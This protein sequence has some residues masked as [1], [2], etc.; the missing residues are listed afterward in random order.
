MNNFPLVTAPLLRQKRRVEV[1]NM[2]RLFRRLWLV[3]A[4]CAGVMSVAQ[5]ETV[6]A[7]KQV[8]VGMYI[9]DITAV[10]LSTNSYSVDFYLWFRWTDP[11]MD[12]V[13]GF[14]FMNMFNPDDHV[15]KPLFDKP[16]P[17]PDGSLYQI[18]RHQGLF[19][20]RFPLN[21]Y[22]FDQQNLL[23]TFEDSQQGSLALQYKP[24]AEGVKLSPRIKLT[25]YQ[26]GQP[27]MQVRA[28]QYDTF[29][30]DLSNPNASAYSRVDI[31]VPITHPIASGIF[32]AFVPVF[33]ILL[34][35]ILALVLDPTHVEAR[36]GLSITA[37]L[38]LVAMQ[39]TMLSN[40]PDVSYLT[41]LDQLFLVSYLWVLGIIAVIV[42]GTRVDNIGDIQGEAGST[43]RMAKHGPRLAL[44]TVS[45]Y[46]VAVA[47]IC[48]V[49]L[50]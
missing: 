43:A 2:A 41:L 14:E 47:I 24:D 34:C 31:A 38:T 10:D 48:A 35:A 16:V 39:F 33:L 45:A 1:A 18:I 26:I 21:T 4:L 8:T 20:N 42:Q 40:L 30:G 12:P 37:L 3:L 11:E 15:Q 32:K 27:S 9:N 46:F 22:P 29:F 50:A 25:G 49:N 28:N 6:P 44:I 36:I 5:A 13:A 17:Q 19:T 23:I 7:P